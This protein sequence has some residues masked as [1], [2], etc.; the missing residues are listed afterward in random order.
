M[1]QMPAFEFLGLLLAW[2]V[3]PYIADPAFRVVLGLLYR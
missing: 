2:Q 3:F 1:R